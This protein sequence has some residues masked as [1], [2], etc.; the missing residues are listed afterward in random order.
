MKA[1]WNK[2]TLLENYRAVVFA[3]KLEGIQ[4]IGAICKAQVF[5]EDNTVFSVESF[6]EHIKEYLNYML[7]MSTW[8]IELYASRLFFDYSDGFSIRM[9]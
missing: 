7:W 1:K 9:T 3:S 8:D 6:V 2:K 4:Q 5:F